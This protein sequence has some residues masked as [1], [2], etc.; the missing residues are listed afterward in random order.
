[1]A[2]KAAD[3]ATEKA[4]GELNEGGF[5]TDDEVEYAR[6]TTREWGYWL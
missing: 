6:V 2:E 3:K 5:R 4:C 1:M